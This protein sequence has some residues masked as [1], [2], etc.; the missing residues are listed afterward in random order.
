MKKAD[1]F[2]ASKWLTENKITFQSRLNE[3][4]D[5]AQAA[6]QEFVQEYKISSY[7]CYV[8]KDGKLLFESFENFHFFIFYPFKIDFDVNIPTG[9]EFSV[10][11]IN[12]NFLLKF[13]FF[14]FN[15]TSSIVLFLSIVKGL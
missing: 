4:V 9:L 12:S 6:L 14:I 10:T 5:G 15:K 3:S 13:L 7:A 8:Y 2:N 11:I 1:N